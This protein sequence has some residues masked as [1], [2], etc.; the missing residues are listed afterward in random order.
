[1]K[2]VLRQAII[3]VAITVVA[4]ELTLQLASLFAEPL[5]ARTSVA[6]GPPDAITILCVGD[7][8]TYGAPLPEQESYPY[9][10]QELLERR[11]PSREFRVVNLGL[12]GVNTAFVANRL[13]R[14]ILEIRPHL[15][16]VSAG[17]NDIW[18]LLHTDSGPGEDGTWTA[19]RRA[20]LHVKL[21]RLA[22]V[23]TSEVHFK[24]PEQGR[25]RWQ[26]S[27]Q[28]RVKREIRNE[29]MRAKPFFGENTDT[30]V[31]LDR[32]RM[33]IQ[34]GMEQ[35]VE[36]ARSFGIPVI[37]YNYPQ[38]DGRRRT[39]SEAIDAAGARLEIPIV[40]S[41]EDVAR[42]V[43]DGRT[44]KELFVWAA[45]PHP[46]ALLY[47]YIVESMV[48][49]VAEALKEWHEID[50]DGERGEAQDEAEMGPTSSCLPAFFSGALATVAQDPMEKGPPRRHRHRHRHL[51]QA[52][53][54]L[55]DRA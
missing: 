35:V 30:R 48:P 33:T 47:S 27:D 10:L 42:A 2:R 37:W 34:Q 54:N 45:G 29:F 46:T 21:F 20:L 52:S 25:G 53:D 6:P 19:L 44:D 14:Q 22:V 9:Q 26:S 17:R 55:E 23:L 12:P 32:A 5:F 31:P 13:K 38:R 4:L 39:A 18:N 49:R 3:A 36:T 28:E 51:Y 40:R 24:P 15:V 11:Y 50:L 43:A 1:M 8:H 16:M 41:E 7:S